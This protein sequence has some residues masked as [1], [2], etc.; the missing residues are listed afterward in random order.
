MSRQIK[1]ISFKLAG[2]D[3]IRLEIHGGFFTSLPFNE[4]KFEFINYLKNEL[5]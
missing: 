3:W 4:I 2:I 5:C 1:L